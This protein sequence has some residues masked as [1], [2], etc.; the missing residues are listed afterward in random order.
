MSAQASSH[1]VSLALGCR[2]ARGTDA[3]RRRLSKLIDDTDLF[4]TEKREQVQRY[5]VR[6]WRAAGFRENTGLSD[7][8]NARVSQQ[9]CPE[10]DDGARFDWLNPAG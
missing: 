1:C 10:V 8:S 4:A 9:P 5:A 2:E 3:V 6:I 7:D